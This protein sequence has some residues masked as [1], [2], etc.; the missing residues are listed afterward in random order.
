MLYSNF[1]YI[2]IWVIWN[3]AKQCNPKQDFHIQIVTCIFYILYIYLIFREL[4]R[5]ISFHILEQIVLIRW[6]KVF[7]RM[8]TLCFVG[9]ERCVTLLYSYASYTLQLHVSCSAISASDIPDTWWWSR[10]P[11]VSIVPDTR[12]RLHWVWLPYCWCV[13]SRWCRR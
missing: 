4:H 1:A 10:S 12:K 8:W 6:N 11:F 9:L 3:Y 5:N 13:R 2:C 7:K